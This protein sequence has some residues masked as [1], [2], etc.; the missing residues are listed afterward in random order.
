MSKINVEF[1][2]NP[3]I[4]HRPI[5]SGPI[6]MAIIYVLIH[7]SPLMDYQQKIVAK[8]LNISKESLSRFSNKI[9]L[10]WKNKVYDET[11]WLKI[12]ISHLLESELY[13]VINNV[14][15]DDHDE[16][17]IELMIDGKNKINTRIRIIRANSTICN[18]LACESK[19]YA[20]RLYDACEGLCML[21]K[22]EK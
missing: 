17:I 1:V 6:S 14:L 21:K 10:N 16:G 3:D 5:K 2:R 22:F 20:R 18:P 7:V 19:M 13:G 8:Y 4:Y 11:I 15:L 12:G 9:G